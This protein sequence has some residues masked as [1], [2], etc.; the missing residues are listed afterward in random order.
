MECGLPGAADKRGGWNAAF[1][2]LASRV[3]LEPR[4]VERY[5]EFAHTSGTT[6]VIGEA[7]LRAHLAI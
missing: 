3:W 2:F 6:D 7:T 5:V 1:P 4:L